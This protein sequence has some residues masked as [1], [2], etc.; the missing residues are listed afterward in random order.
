MLQ[1]KKIIFINHQND[2]N[3]NSIEYT[4][5]F[6]TS[7]FAWGDYVF[8]KTLTCLFNF[9][10]TKVNIACTLNEWMNEWMNGIYKGIPLS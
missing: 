1:K 4:R 3:Q 10:W 5:E 6:N 9:E 2:Y 8:H 7:M